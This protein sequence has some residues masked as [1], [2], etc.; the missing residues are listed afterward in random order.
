MSK[1]HL[2]SKLEITGTSRF[3]N[4]QWNIFNEHVKCLGFIV[5]VTNGNF[6]THEI[7]T[8]KENFEIILELI[9]D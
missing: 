1:K 7:N 9:K 6:L 4:Q 8:T 5:K 2:F 3:N